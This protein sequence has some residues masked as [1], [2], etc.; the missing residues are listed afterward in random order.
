MVS[1]GGAMTWTRGRNSICSKDVY[2]SGVCRLS[3]RAGRV[4]LKRGIRS[5]HKGCIPAPT[6]KE[7]GSKQSPAQR[8]IPGSNGTNVPNRQRV[9]GRGEAFFAARAAWV[10]YSVGVPRGARSEDR[11]GGWIGSNSA[12]KRNIPR[13][14]APW[15]RAGCLPRNPKG[16]RRPG[17]THR[18]G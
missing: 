6:M 5:R 17:Q 14:I 4:R 11:G 7:C 16:A 8:E 3:R 2:N 10:R 13:E 9:E 18:K 15:R 1:N 12:K